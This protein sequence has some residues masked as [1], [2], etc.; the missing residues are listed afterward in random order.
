MLLGPSSLRCLLP[1][2][3][4]PSP[5]LLGPSPLRRLLPWVRASGW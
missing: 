5:L 2:L 4:G 3:L 1:S